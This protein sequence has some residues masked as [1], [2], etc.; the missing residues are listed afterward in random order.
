MFSITSQ[1]SELEQRVIEAEE[2]ANDA[3]DKVR[4]CLRPVCFIIPRAIPNILPCCVY[5]QIYI[6]RLIS[7]RRKLPCGVP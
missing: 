3:E 2:R 5:K 7:A 4:D 6:G 1:L